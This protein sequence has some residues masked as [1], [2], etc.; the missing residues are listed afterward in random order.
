MTATAI[1]GG[2]WGSEGKGVVAHALAHHFDAAVRVGGPNAGHS[3]YEGDARHVMRGVPCAWVND[4]C[5]LVIGAGAV[6]D[7]DLLR[8]ELDA[9]PGVHITVDRTAAIVTHDDAKHEADTGLWEAIGSTTEGVGAARRRKMNRRRE[10]PHVLAGDLP[11]RDWHPRAH[12]VDDTAEYLSRLIKAGGDVM[13]EGTQGSGLSLI[14][15]TE[16]PFMTSADTNAGGLCADT[17]VAPAHLEHT[18]LVARTL[19]IRVA[20]NSGPMGEELDWADLMAYAGV[21]KPEKTTVTKRVRRISRWY[22]PVFTKAVA[23]NQPCGVFLMFADYL[24]PDAAGT[25]DVDEL[26]D[27]ASTVNPLGD[28][29]A[30]ADKIETKYNVPILAYGTGGDRW[31][32][33][34]NGEGTCHHGRRW[35][36]TRR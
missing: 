1:V 33:A 17:G 28:L 6:V 20:G 22:D 8:E 34:W 15:G 31:A 18:F 23:V 7:P 35:A 32:L 9:L 4:T 10:I 29:R 5:E 13:L 12:L 14:H 3:F 25:T 2:Q 19:P 27:R 26:M 21:Q 24:V 36:P 11:A 16:W 30:L